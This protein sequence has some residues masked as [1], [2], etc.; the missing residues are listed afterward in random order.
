M[1]RDS[2][3]EKRA[4][5]KKFRENVKRW[6]GQVWKNSY[7]TSCLPA[8]QKALVAEIEIHYCYLGC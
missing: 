5:Q 1:K 2:K 3:K 4:S 7:L 8:W 6:G